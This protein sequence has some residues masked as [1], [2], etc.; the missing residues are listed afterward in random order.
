MSKSSIRRFFLIGTQHTT[1]QNEIKKIRLINL[2]ALIGIGLSVLFLILNL[3]QFPDDLVKHLSL[4]GNL[5][6]MLCIVGLNYKGFF[7]LSRVLLFAFVSFLFFY[8]A[9]FAYKGFYSEYFYLLLPI[10]G[11]LFFEHLA[12]HLI[13]L[14]LAVAL[15]YVPNLYFHVYA[16][17]SFGY[18]NV[19]FLFAGIFALVRYFKRLNQ[20]NEKLLAEQKDKELALIQSRSLREQIDSHFISNAMVTIQNFIMN[21][22]QESANQYLTTFSRLMR[23]LLETSRKEMISISDEAELLEDFLKLSKARYENTFDYRIEID[24]EIDPELDEIPAMFIQPF[25]EN[26][27]EHGKYGASNKGLIEIRFSRKDDTIEILVQDN[28]GGFIKS[29][30]SRKNSLST[31]ILKERL[32]LLNK[33][34]KKEHHFHVVNLE[35]EMNQPIGTMITII[36]QSH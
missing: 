2:F 24:E 12:I 9:N 13:S 14:F 33:F 20:K 4:I 35:N 31:T 5:V 34:S 3:I 1:D 32:E 22:D 19:A 26:A 8:N 23:S 30:N 29:D 28:G 18:A 36:F 25:V 6:F 27:V 15:F 11:L 16:E 21:N 7:T 17:N 10:L